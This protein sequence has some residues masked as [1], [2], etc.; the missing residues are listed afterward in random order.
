[1]NNTTKN[2]IETH[3]DQAYHVAVQLAV[4]SC[5]VKDNEW[6]WTFSESARELMV[7]GYHNNPQKDVAPV[8]PEP[9]S[10]V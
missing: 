7:L 5:K 8:P 6:A 9:V 2:L 3:G 1:M 10:E 4:I